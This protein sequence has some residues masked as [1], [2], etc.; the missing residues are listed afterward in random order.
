LLEK[1]KKKS[2][3]Y[4]DKS[5]KSWKNKAYSPDGNFT[6]FPSSQIRNEIV[7]KDL[8]ASKNFSSRILD[9]GCA[10]GR[11]IRDMLNA[12]FTQVMGIDNSAVMIDEAKKLLKLEFPELDADKIFFIADADKISINN[13]FDY[14]TAIGL[15]EYVQDINIFLSSVEN[16]L[17]DNGSAYIESRNKL[18]NLVTANDYTLNIDSPRELIEE[19]DSISHLS[20]IKGKDKEKLLLNTYQYIGEHLNESN[21]NEPKEIKVFDK[22]PFDLPQYSPLELMQHCSFSNLL[23]DEVVYY[24]CHPFAPR[25]GEEFSQLFNQL[26]VLMQ[27]IGYTNLGAL[28]CSAF[29]AKVKKSK[30]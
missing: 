15:I 3:K 22:Y 1:N 10:D 29:V 5:A 9:I 2:I 17:D 4:W 13:K 25:F 30:N 14:V 7:I 11:L 8:I 12:G 28:I 24:H 18:F 6:I 21:T 27:P 19:L 23:V 20:P 26:G 16:L